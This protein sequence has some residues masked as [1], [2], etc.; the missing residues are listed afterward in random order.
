MLE[1]VGEMV[2][3]ANDVA[4]AEIGIVGTGGEMVCRIAIGAEQGEIFDVDASFNLLSIDRIIEVDR[5]FVFV[6]SD[7]RRRL[8]PHCPVAGHTK[9]K[10]ER[11]AGSRPAVAFLAGKFAHPGI[12]EPR[13]L[14]TRP[15]A[16]AGMG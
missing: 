15:L 13:T 1:G 16:V 5:Q 8:S 10:G 12:K 2:L 9:A 7:S 6:K 11:L 14:S 3:A 4:D